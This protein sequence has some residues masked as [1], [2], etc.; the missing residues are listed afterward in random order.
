MTTSAGFTD[1]T[2]SFLADLAEN[3]TREWFEEHRDRYLHDLIEPSQQ[4]ILAV[5]EELDR[6]SPSLRADPRRV[7]GSMFRIHRDLRFSKDKTPYK[8]HAGIQFRHSAGKDA[9][10]PGLYVHVEPENCFV[11]LGVW[12]PA[13]APLRAIRT[14]LV[15]APERWRAA[16]DAL[17]QEGF[18]LAGDSLKRI[19]RGFDGEH[20]LADDLRRKDFIAVAE[21]E[22]GRVVSPDFARDVVDSAMAG[23]PLLHLLC[24]ALDVAR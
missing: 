3:N 1:A 6:L 23:Q 11:G 16:V 13:S 19:P 7:G 22:R 15:D 12:R 18:A 4:F 8:T 14:A 17:S 20:P 24:D 9:H 21:L 2:F 10:A 5:G